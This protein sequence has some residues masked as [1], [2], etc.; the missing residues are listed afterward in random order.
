M[1]VDRSPSAE[2]QL[3]LEARPPAEDAC[4]CQFP[5]EER[6]EQLSEDKGQLRD[7]WV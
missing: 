1:P 3:L 6:G 2:T 4:S 5:E 7:L